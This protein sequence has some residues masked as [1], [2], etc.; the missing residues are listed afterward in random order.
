MRINICKQ[1]IDKRKLLEA[2]RKYETNGDRKAD[3]VMNISTAESLGNGDVSFES[4][5][6]VSDCDG[7]FGKYEANK[8]FIN[9]N[10]PFGEV[11]IR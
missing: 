2:I 3:L 1:E 11:D 5:K 8:I 4:H 6:D 7:I 9:N 10:F